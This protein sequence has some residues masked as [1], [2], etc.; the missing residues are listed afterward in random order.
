MDQTHRVGPVKFAE[1]FDAI[2]PV[3]LIKS[4]GQIISSRFI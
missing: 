1:A 2:L 4:A 3:V